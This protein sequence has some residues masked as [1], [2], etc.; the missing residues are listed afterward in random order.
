VMIQLKVAN[1]TTKK[2]SN[3]DTRVFEIAFGANR[4]LVSLR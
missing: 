3:R 2:A 1:S 4:E